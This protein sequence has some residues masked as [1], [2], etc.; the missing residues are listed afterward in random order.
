MFDMNEFKIVDLP[1]IVNTIVSRVHW[2]SRTELTQ[3]TL[4]L[5]ESEV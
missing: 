5:Q 1:F 2:Q 4:P 3:Y